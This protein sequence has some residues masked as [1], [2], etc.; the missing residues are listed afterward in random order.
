MNIAAMAVIT[1]V[2]FAEKRPCRADGHAGRQLRKCL[3][4]HHRDGRGGR[5]WSAG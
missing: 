5:S 4:L 2:I 3:G 1:F